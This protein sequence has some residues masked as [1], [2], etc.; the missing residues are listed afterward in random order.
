M[1]VELLG[2]SVFVQESGS[3][4]A[5]KN[6]LLL[7]GWGCSCELMASVQGAFEESMRVVS[8]DFPGHGKSAQPPEPWGVPEYAEMTGELIEDRKSTRLNSSHCRISR[9]PSSA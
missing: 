8:I 4:N 3:Q 1:Q 9:M 2:A 5:G 6:L 7:H